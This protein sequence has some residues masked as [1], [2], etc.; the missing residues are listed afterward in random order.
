M[1]DIIVFKK[2]LWEQEVSEPVNAAQRALP[3][4]P[5][6]KSSNER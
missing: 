3:G 2:A 4:P 6:A 5:V 1:G